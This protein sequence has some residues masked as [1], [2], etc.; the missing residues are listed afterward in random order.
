[1]V[2]IG[3]KVL[4]LTFSDGNMGYWLRYTVTEG[5]Y[6]VKRY[7]WSTIFKAGAPNG[8]RIPIDELSFRTDHGINVIGPNLYFSSVDGVARYNGDE[9]GWALEV[10]GEPSYNPVPLILRLIRRRSRY[11]M[12]YPYALFRGVVKHGGAEYFVDDA[13]GMVGYIASNRYMHHWVWGHC[14]GFDG[15]PSGWLDILMVSPDGVKEIVFGALKYLGKVY[16]IGG[17]MGSSFLGSYGL[18]FFKGR[19]GASRLTLEF[20]FR[21]D[22]SD[23]I[24]ARY[25]DPV[26]G[27]RFCHNSEVADADLTIY[28]DGD[29]V[30]LGCKKRAFMEYVCPE[31][32]DDSLA[33]IV[34]LGGSNIE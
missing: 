13:L 26:E 18:G 30:R 21:A 27:I 12:V 16:R 1:M 29:E 7:L 3:Y 10:T 11:I 2:S 28:L 14:T 32:L 31:L 24:V 6:G 17:L 8:V 20:S 34:E 5:V 25:E 9:Y 22:L 23:L 15:D 33:S 4:F 19:V